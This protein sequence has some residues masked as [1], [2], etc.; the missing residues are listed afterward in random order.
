MMDCSIGK[1]GWEMSKEKPIF[2]AHVK[3]KK[4]QAIVNT[5][6]AQ[7]L[8]RADLA[9]QNWAPK[10]DAV[11]MICM[12]EQPLVY[13]RKKYLLEILD[14]AKEM[15]VGLPKDLPYLMILGRDWKEIYNILDTVRR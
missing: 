2:W 15:P 1:A 10:T 9:P 14:H 5:G 3:G 4:I 8:F 13:P 11:K 7:T 12:H 6:C